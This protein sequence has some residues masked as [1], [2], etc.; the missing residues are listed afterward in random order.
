MKE[1]KNNTSTKAQRATACLPLSCGDQKILSY[2]APASPL[3]KS[4]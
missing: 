2:P 4:I 1:Y 3:A